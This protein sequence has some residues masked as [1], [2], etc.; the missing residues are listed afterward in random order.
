[1]PDAQPPHLPDDPE[2]HLPKEHW[3]LP[4]LSNVGPESPHPPAT[5]FVDVQQSPEFQKL[6]S[7][8]RGFAF[9]TVVAVLVWYFL[10]VGLSTFAEDFMSLRTSGNTR[11]A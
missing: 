7:A 10:Y 1:M 2:Y 9:P 8:F 4:E 11:P 6:R 3:P 5:T